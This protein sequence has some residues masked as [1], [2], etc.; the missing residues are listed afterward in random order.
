MFVPLDDSHHDTL[1]SSILGL[2]LLIPTHHRPG[3][4]MPLLSCTLYQSKSIN[5]L[6]PERG[7]YDLVSLVACRLCL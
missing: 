1:V 2:L 7:S 6:G 5:K 3:I 4:A